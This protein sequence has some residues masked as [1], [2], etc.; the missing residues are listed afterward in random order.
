MP[1]SRVRLA[2]VNDMREWMPVADNNS[3]MKPTSQATAVRVQFSCASPP[4]ARASGF[5]S[6]R[7][8]V[9]ST[10]AAMARSRVANSAGSRTRT[11][12]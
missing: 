7:R 6:V 11:A 4:P 10:S 3:T 5:I 2:T 12:S 8:I 9:G 1:I